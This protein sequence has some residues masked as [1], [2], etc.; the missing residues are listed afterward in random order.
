M[1]NKF[2]LRDISTLNLDNKYVEFSICYGC[3]VKIEL[4]F[5]L[6]TR[7]LYFDWPNLIKEANSLFFVPFYDFFTS[8]LWFL[9]KI[10]PA[11]NDQN[12]R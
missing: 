12:K 7:A 9:L 2:R 10:D 6:Y 4:P 11:Y 3:S 8:V 5:L 1:Q